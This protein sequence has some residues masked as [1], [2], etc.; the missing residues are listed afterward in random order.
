VLQ[1]VQKP[2]F[3]KN[4]G[5]FRERQMHC[6]RLALA[7]LTASRRRLRFSVLPERMGSKHSRLRLAVKRKCAIF[8]RAQYIRAFRDQF[9]SGNLPFGRDGSTPPDSRSK[10]VFVTRF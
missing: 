2:G 4:P 9:Q 6:A 3:L 5:Y 1:P 10:V 8:N 7:R